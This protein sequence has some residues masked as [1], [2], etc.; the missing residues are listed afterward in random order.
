MSWNAFNVL[1]SFLKKKPRSSEWCVLLQDVPGAAEAGGPHR[2]V[3]VP[4]HRSLHVG[5]RRAAGE[6]DGG[7]SSLV[8]LIPMIPIFQCFFG[9]KYLRKMPEN[10]PG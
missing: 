3:H 10:Q 4:L 1:F 8:V 6:G 2:E 9:F 5:G 7:K